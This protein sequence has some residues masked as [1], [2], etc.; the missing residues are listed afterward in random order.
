VPALPTPCTDGE[1]VFAY[2]ATYGLVALDLDGQLL[3][4][5]RFPH[6]GNGFGVGL[7]PLLADGKVILVRDGAPEAAIFAFDAEDGSEAW[8]IDRFGFIESHG[9]PFL[10]KNAGRTELIVGGTGQVCSFD[11]SNGKP[12]WNVTGVTIFNCTT[13]TMDAES[14]YF[15]GWS[16][17]N[18]SGRSFWEA[19]FGR[20]LELSDAEVADP[21]LIFKRMDANGDG[22]LVLDEIPESRFKDAFA[23]LDEDENGTLDEGEVVGDDSRSKP[24]GKNVM[25]A[26][27]R[28]GSG[29]VTE[30][31]VRWKWSRGLPYVASPLLYGGRVWL[32][33]AGGMVSCLD[34]ESGKRILDRERLED[35]SEYYMSPV[36]A[37]GHVILGSAEGTLYILKA[38]SDE[39]EIVHQADFGEGLF[40]TPAIVDGKVYLRT[41][42]TLWAFGAK[43]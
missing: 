25:L 32:V 3:W 33:K 21:K 11:P 18:S 12:L 40:A 20:S 37:F 7:S 31:H 23:F 4:E 14:L 27:A 26:I 39:L 10:W 2:L 30:T 29:D 35:R 22:I 15:A 16:T 34:A 6:P 38:D 1:R 41:E 9:S 5:K 28:G 42:R 19:G 43:D 8:K 24:P 17:G 13:P 36:G